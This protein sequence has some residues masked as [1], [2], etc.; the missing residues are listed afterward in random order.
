MAYPTEDERWQRIEELLRPKPTPPPVNYILG[1][2]QR[3]NIPGTR[4]H[5]ADQYVPVLYQPKDSRARTSD[6]PADAVIDPSDMTIRCIFDEPHGEFRDNILVK[7][8]IDYLFPI[9]HIWKNGT[10]EKA[11]LMEQKYRNDVEGAKFA[12]E[13]ARDVPELAKGESSDAANELLA[14]QMAPVENKL[15]DFYEGLVGMEVKIEI[16]KKGLS[17]RQ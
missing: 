17:F 1:F 12:A 10:E 15:R 11:D 6:L 3:R 2:T 5:Q 7:G 14:S 13:R 9:A 4:P 8:P 16:A